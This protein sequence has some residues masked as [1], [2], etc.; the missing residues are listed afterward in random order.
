MDGY[1]LYISLFET[2]YNE[3]KV[4]MKGVFFS[5]PKSD[6]LHVL[7]IHE[8]GVVDAG[9][10]CF[11]YPDKRY[12]VLTGMEKKSVI[13]RDILKPKWINLVT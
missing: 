10:H 13:L 5:P 4:K 8:S 2:L 7:K 1:S 3:N 11:N 9:L 6:M 12:R